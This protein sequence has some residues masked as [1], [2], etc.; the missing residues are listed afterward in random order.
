MKSSAHGE[1]VDKLGR[2]LSYLVAISTII[3][4]PTGLYGYLSSIHAKKAE[5][6]YEYYRDFRSEAFQK[7]WILL[8]NR[9][10]EKAGEVQQIIA[11][12]DFDR[13]RRLTTGLV[14]QDE[15]GK[16]AFARAVGFFDEAYACVEN[17]LCDHNVAVLLLKTPA[18]E[19][20]SAFGSHIVFIRDEYKSTKYGSGAFK[21][22]S[23]ERQFSVF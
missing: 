14:N 13:L 18:S 1:P 23:L 5:R 20:V 12:K 6:T 10:N 2:V 16:T 15:A 7:D 19:F 22:R 9:W 17:S 4:I 8:L 11:V 3:G 21:V